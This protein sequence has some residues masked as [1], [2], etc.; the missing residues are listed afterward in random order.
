MMSGAPPF[1]SQ[2][3]KKMVEDRMT[4]PIEMLDCFSSDTKMIL[5]GLLELE[6]YYFIVHK[7]K[8]HQ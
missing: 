1:Y 6:V 7:L 8:A 5:R 2:D 3:K 4:K